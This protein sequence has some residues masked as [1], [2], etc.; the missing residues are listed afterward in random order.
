MK[1]LKEAIR[2]MILSLICLLFFA[3]LSSAQED[4]VEQALEACQPEIE[5]YCSQ[6]TPGDGRLLACFVAHEDKL[7]G[8]CGW[9]LYEAMDELE[10]FMEAVAYV[11][12]SCWDDIVEHCSEVE[13]GEGRIAVCLLEHEGEVS[14]ACKEAMA[15]VELEVIE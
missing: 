3:G 9:A 12:E 7:S 2:M 8:Q 14:P 11:A 15:E 10:A 6:V 5:S 13:M 1:N 4:I